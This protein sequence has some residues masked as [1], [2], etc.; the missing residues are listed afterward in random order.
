MCNAIIT[1]ILLGST[2]STNAR[3]QKRVR[4]F[5]VEARNN[6][7]K[8]LRDPSMMLSWLLDVW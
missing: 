4:L 8:K 6:S 3:E 1:N 5:C 7:W 2:S